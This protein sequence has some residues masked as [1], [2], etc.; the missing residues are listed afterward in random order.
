MFI[1]F[2]VVGLNKKSIKSYV[3][4]N[5]KNKSVA[6]QPGIQMHLI[7]KEGG[8]GG[9]GGEV[10]RS[11]EKMRL[12]QFHI[13]INVDEETKLQFIECVLNTDLLVKDTKLKM[14]Y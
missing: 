7:W 3:I 11:K 6:V 13:Q 1:N 12:V 8:T 5:F 2:Y 10:R 9:G 14:N 4:S